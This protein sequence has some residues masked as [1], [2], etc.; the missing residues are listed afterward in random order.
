M[1]A[2]TDGSGIADRGRRHA[3]R[4]LSTRTPIEPAPWPPLQVEESRPNR[5]SWMLKVVRLARLH[6]LRQ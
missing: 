4:V 1:A 6:G 2:G 3:V 5:S